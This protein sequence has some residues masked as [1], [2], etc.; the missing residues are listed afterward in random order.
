[1]SLESMSIM[2]TN[3][4][5]TLGCHLKTPT[6]SSEQYERELKETGTPTPILCS[7]PPRT[8]PKNVVTTQ[9]KNPFFNVDLTKNKLYMKR[10]NRKKK[11]MM[12]Q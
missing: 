12:T 10:M 4:V 1:M 5:N 3:L 7:T 2:I 8:I 11:Q 9:P 6:V